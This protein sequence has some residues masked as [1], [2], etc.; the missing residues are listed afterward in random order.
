MPAINNAKHGAV[1]F[2][3]ASG[4][5]IVVTLGPGEGNFSISGLQEGGALTDVV[6]D[7]GDVYERV[8][9]EEA[10]YSGSITVHLDG[11]L[12]DPTTATVIDAVMKSGAMSSGTTDEPGGQTWTG[13]ISAVWTRAGVVNTVAIG[14]ARLTVDLSEGFPA[15]QLTVN[16]EAPGK[17]TTITTA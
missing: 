4:S 2:S 9:T 13:T 17:S 5:P 1:T 11:D 14:E 12:T 15:N 7:R 6:R 3:D 10:I 8:C 16:F